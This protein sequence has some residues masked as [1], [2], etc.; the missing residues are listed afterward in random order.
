[1]KPSAACDSPFIVC[2]HDATPAFARE[3]ETII[4]ALAEMIGS[5]FSIGVVPDWDGEWPIENSPDYCRMLEESAQQ[6]LLHGY[7]HRRAHGRGIVS[8]LAERSDEMNVMDDETSRRTLAAGQQTFIAAFGHSAAG[9]VPPAWQ[10]GRVCPGAA[11]GLDHV[12]GF[13]S[14]D[15]ARRSIPVAT[16]SWD[17]GRWGWLGHIGHAAGGLSHTMRGGVPSIA[18]H[19]RDVD[20][21]YMPAILRVIRQLLD[22]GHVPSTPARVI[23][24]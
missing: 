23:A 12:L 21:G 3:T 20:R 9:F 1:M 6:L 14:V 4:R 2:L 18:V 16:W 13:F 7:R 10:R 15:T 5:R 11:Y 8:L 22:T 19:P 24:A 17:C